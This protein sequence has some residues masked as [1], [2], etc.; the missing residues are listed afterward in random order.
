MFFGFWQNEKKKNQNWFIRI[1]CFVSELWLFYWLFFY[2]F[3]FSFRIDVFVKLQ[4]AIVDVS[5]PLA[6]ENQTIKKTKQN[7]NENFISFAFCMRVFFYF[8]NTQIIMII[9]ERIIVFPVRLGILSPLPFR[10]HTA[11]QTIR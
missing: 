11:Q 10:H 2:L 9:F 8:S 1:L 6:N 3:C 5:R 7:T 4:H